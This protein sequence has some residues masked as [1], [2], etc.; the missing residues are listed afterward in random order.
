MSMDAQD[1]ANN[2][3]QMLWTLI[4]A[5]ATVNIT[6]RFVKVTKGDYEY[7]HDMNGANVRAGSLS[8]VLQSCVSSLIRNR[9]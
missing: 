8:L 5:G 9:T 2:E 3:M 6:E 1:I 4:D 7:V